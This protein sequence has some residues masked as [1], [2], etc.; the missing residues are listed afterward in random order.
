MAVMTI[1]V[2]TFIRIA[3]CRLFIPAVPWFL[4][5]GLIHDFISNQSYWGK[6]R[7]LE[8][9]RVTIEYSICFGAYSNEDQIGFCRAV[10]DKVAFAYIMDLFVVKPFRGQGIGKLLIEEML[11]HPELKTVNWLLATDGAHD[12]YTKF[13]FSK[14]E[15][16]DRYMKRAG[17]RGGQ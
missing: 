8:Q 5:C 9:V 16:S 15:G 7:T 14:V 2:V 11:T 4:I 12:L 1:T 10:T 13:G 6:G 17:A 3:F